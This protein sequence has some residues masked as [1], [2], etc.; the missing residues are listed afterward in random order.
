[1]EWVIDI[2]QWQ[3][4][5]HWLQYHLRPHSEQRKTHVKSLAHLQQINSTHPI[6]IGP[7]WA[8]NLATYV[9]MHTLLSDK[10]TVIH[11]LMSPS[12]DLTWLMSLKSWLTKS[13][14]PSKSLIASARESMVSMSRW[15]VGS[16]SNRRWGQRN[17]NHAKITRQRCPSDKFLMG[18]IYANMHIL[19]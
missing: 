3:G 15:L 14:P 16:S 18:Q 5:T 9:H 17:A 1:M 8:Q 13:T 4:R 12:C 7:H 2:A 11:S 6:P 10:S 19:T